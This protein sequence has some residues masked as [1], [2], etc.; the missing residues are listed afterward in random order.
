M[1]GVL[2]IA[3]NVSIPF[4]APYEG[5]GLYNTEYRTVTDLTHR[6]YFFELSTSPNVVW[7]DLDQLDLAEG[8]PVRA[9]DPDDISLSGEVSSRYA[10][11]TDPFATT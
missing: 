5:F 10:E 7:T 6:R 9:L 1:A 4:G 8:A 3:R 2:A 11:S